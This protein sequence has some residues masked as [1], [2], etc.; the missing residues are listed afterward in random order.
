MTAPQASISPDQR[1]EI[2]R[3]ARDLAYND[4]LAALLAP[5]QARDDL[6]TLAAYSGEIA[7]I[8]LQV[9][10]APLG[11]IRLQWW[12]DALQSGGASGHPVA[13]ALNQIKVRK[14]LPLDDLL[15]PLE[16]RA[17]ELYPEP[18]PDDPAFR[19]YVGAVEGAELRLRARVL[20]EAADGANATL[21]ADATHVL[22]LTHYAVR[23][24]LL[25]AKGRTPIDVGRLGASEP[26]RS[27]GSMD[28]TALRASVAFLVAEAAAGLEALL[29]KVGRA[30]PPIRHVLLPLALAGPYLEVLQGD[31]HDVLRNVAE[32]SP[33]ARSIRLWRAARLGWF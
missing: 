28:E 27:H 2:M 23:L 12:R 18:F 21:F 20:G 1:A 19:A 11:E 32:P 10:E 22:G 33:L 31:Q 24:P 4:Y 29:P 25:L 26:G 30:Q 7:R 17:A 16:A 3:T 9:S 5:R 6:L 13:D 14:T 15:A 8:P